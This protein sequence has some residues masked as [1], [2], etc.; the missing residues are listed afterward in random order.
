MNWRFRRLE[1]G[2][3]PLLFEWLNGEEVKCWYTKGSIN[4]ARI[5]EK[6]LPCVKGTSPKLTMI[7]MLDEEPVG[8]LQAYSLSDYPAY[9]DQV[10]IVDSVGID[11]FIGKATRM[12]QGLG[13]RMLKV[14]V[15]DVISDYFSETIAVI[16]PEP[17]NKRAIRAYEKAGF[18]FSHQIENP[19]EEIHEY[20]MKRN[21]PKKRE[22]SVDR[23]DPIEI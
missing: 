9:A 12:N 14:F 10:G 2:D 11:L 6:Y 18:H 17:E 8:F 22:I 21:I 23:N 16:G 15:Q 13:S 7:A 20:L 19:R 1:Q 3:F 4:Q 5:E